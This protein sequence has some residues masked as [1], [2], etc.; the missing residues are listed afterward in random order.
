MN[1]LNVG[2]LC[3]GISCSN[4]SLTELGIDYNIVAVEYDPKCKRLVKTRFPNTIQ[5]DKVEDVTGESLCNDLNGMIDLLLISAPCQDISVQGK[6]RGLSTNSG[7]HIYSYDEYDYY[8]KRGE[9]FTRSSTYW[10]CIRVHRELLKINSNLN[11]LSENVVN[12]KWEDVM[13]KALGC[14]PRIINTHD[15]LPQNRNRC[16]L[17][18]IPVNSIIPSNTKLGDIIP[19]ADTGAGWHGVYNKTLDAY[20]QTLSLKKGNMA[21]CITTWKSTKGRPGTKF[22]ADLERNIYPFTIEH[23]ERLQGLPVGYTDLPGLTDEDR[24][25]MI[26][27]CWSIPVIVHLL[28]N[29]VGE[30]VY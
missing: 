10:E 23:L 8:K 3:D 25:K 11:V 29:L 22:Y 30:L 24:M 6:G 1:K 13:A 2:V 18:D 19:G 26:G 7:I 16:Y 28:K 17:T 5:R 21:K 4:L 15:F 9:T 20:V 27:N 14:V 12:K